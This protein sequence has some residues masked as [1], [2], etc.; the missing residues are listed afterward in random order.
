M[1]VLPPEQ[2]QTTPFERSPH[3]NS[4]NIA[5]SASRPRVRTSLTIATT[6]SATTS[7]PSRQRRHTATP[8]STPSPLPLRTTKYDRGSTQQPPSS[9]EHTPHCSRPHGE[10]NR[11]LSRVRNHSVRPSSRIRHVTDTLLSASTTSPVTTSCPHSTRVHASHNTYLARDSART[12][13]APP[14]PQTKPAATPL[15]APVS[16]QETEHLP[17][18]PTSTAHSLGAPPVRNSSEKTSPTALPPTPTT[19]TTPS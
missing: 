1:H 17:T 18:A 4:E 16:T 3:E 19:Q 11:P 2:R 13:T 5:R 7:N 14:F 8:A 10:G 9:P 6:R 15:P 12:P